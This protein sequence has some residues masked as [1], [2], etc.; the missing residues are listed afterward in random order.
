MDKA[1]SSHPLARVGIIWLDFGRPR[2]NA[3]KRSRVKPKFKGKRL[4]CPSVDACRY[5]F[6]TAGTDEA[7]ASQHFSIVKLS[8]TSMVGNVAT[9]PVT[10][11]VP[12]SGFI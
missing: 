10:E 4:A 8:L 3:S 12:A 2:L 1:G 6:V 7:M 5:D 9:L 11:Y